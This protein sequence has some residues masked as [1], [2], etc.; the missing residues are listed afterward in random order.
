[1]RHQF[2][3]VL[4]LVVAVGM[5]TAQRPSTASICDYY[6]MERYGANSSDSQFRLM[7]HI[8][9][10]AFGGGVGLPDASDNSTG[11][12]N[13]G[14][15]GELAVD[16]RP[17]FDGSK[18][19]T[20][21]NNQA[22]GIDWLDDGAQEPLMAFLNGTTSSVELDESSNEYRLFAHFY[23]AFGRIYGCTLTSGFPKANDSGAPIAPAY[24]HKF[25]NLNQTD[26]GHFINQLILSSKYAGFSDDDANTL[27][28]FL[29]SRYNVRCAPAI[30]GQLYSLCQAP[31][32]PLA[33]PSA[34][35]NAYVNI[36]PGEGST[37]TGGSGAV[38]SSTS[39]PTS[40]ATSTSS[41]QPTTNPPSSTATSGG[42]A[43]SSGAIA[44]IAI[45]GA[46][47]VLLAV[48]L[49]LYH[50][51]RQQAKPPQMPY[52]G[53]NSYPPTSPGYPP[54]TPTL[55]PHASYAPS[56]TVR[57]SHLAPGSVY[58]P[59]QPEAELGVPTPVS[60]HSPSNMIQAV[61]MESPL[62][63]EVS[64]SVPQGRFGESANTWAPNGR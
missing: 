53:V 1:M 47:V 46:A 26:L 13:P 21:L 36:G 8:V 45:G 40:S 27:D 9:A 62:P 43:L 31:E 54:Y 19:T 56:S 61:E 35:C 23:S 17:W 24:V 57:D 51:R 48:G 60:A 30:D 63:S 5:G 20:N 55:G 42:P 12:L 64:G 50:R 7:E 25:M 11:I 44:G 41:T 49:W 15:F 6:A 39:Q 10:L 22:V 4:L 28:T 14:S 32:C 18:A 29:N 58:E 33:A 59:K 34:D 16:L 37:A 38:P 2:A 52:P 3:A